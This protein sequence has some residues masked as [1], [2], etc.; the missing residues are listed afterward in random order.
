MIDRCSTVCAIQCAVL[1]VHGGYRSSASCRFQAIYLIWGPSAGA[2]VSGVLVYEIS[3]LLEAEHASRRFEPPITKDV[4][5]KTLMC[6]AWALFVATW[7][8]W[9]ILQ[10]FH[11]IQSVNGLTC[12]PTVTNEES[13]LFLWFWLFPCAVGFPYFYI[14]YM[15]ADIWKRKL[16]P[17]IGNSARGI[18]IF[19]IGA[20]SIFLV[21]WV[22]VILTMFAF[23]GVTSIW[24][25]Y[26]T[27]LWS[28]LQG[29]ITS[30]FILFC[31]D[32]RSEFVSFV[33]CRGSST[34]FL[35]EAS[36]DEQ[37]EREE[38]GEENQDDE[39]KIEVLQG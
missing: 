33:C 13:E 16:L 18:A 37:E 23:P 19:F 11:S 14:F 5:R 34:N 2:W 20:T 31:Q 29:S 30:C 9:G 27:G 7:S 38:E 36:K 15:I 21:V 22:P 17:P 8:M 3:R 6:Y 25:P 26:F 32:V 4:I 24:W 10:P 35:E 12:L 39:G 28:H 1:A